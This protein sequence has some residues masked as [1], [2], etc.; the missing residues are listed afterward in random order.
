MSQGTLMKTRD[1]M[2]ATVLTV[3]LV[4][5]M[6]GQETHDAKTTS[7]LKKHDMSSM[8]G[9]PTVDATVDGLHLKVWLMTQNEHKEMMKGDMGQMMKRSENDAPIERME[10]R[11]MK[12]TTM[13]MG[14]DMM[15]MKHEGMGMRKGMR[16]S[17]M[18]GTHHIVLDVTDVSG[19]RDVAKASAKVVIV[20]PSKKTSSVDLKPRMSHFAGALTLDEKGEYTL[21]VSVNVSGVATTKQFPYAVK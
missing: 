12:D 7:D 10:T 1:A 20:S 14:K 21:T 18:A 2:L 15:G 17:M 9:N 3:A 13:G 8:M 6:F 16:D 11:K 4:L 5:P 19:G